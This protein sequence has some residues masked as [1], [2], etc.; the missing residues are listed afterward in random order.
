MSGGGVMLLCDATP[1]TKP[2]KSGLLV[3]PVH[4]RVGR[5]AV[6]VGPC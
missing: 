2:Q 5:K 4:G 6:E 3:M 1:R